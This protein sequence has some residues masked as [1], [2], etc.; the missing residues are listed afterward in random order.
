MPPRELPTIA[1]QHRRRIEQARDDAISLAGNAAKIAE[2]MTE[3]LEQ[4]GIVNVQPQINFM[5]GAQARFL[6]DY[7]VIEHLQNIGAFQKKP[8]IR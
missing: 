6:K 5:T 2:A 3:V 7:G 4:G 8:S 1:A